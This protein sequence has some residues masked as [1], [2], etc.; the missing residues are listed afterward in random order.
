MDQVRKLL[1]IVNEHLIFSLSV[2]MVLKLLQEIQVFFPPW[3]N[4][5]MQEGS[6]N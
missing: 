4:Y 3:F 6:A 5:H 1:L 2:S